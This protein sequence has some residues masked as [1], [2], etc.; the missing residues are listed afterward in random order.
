MIKLFCIFLIQGGSIRHVNSGRCLS[1]PE[2]RDVTL[3]VLK[4]CDESIS[5]QWV[6]KSRF[7]CE[8]LI[9]LCSL[10]EIKTIFLMQGKQQQMTNH[11]KIYSS[12]NFFIPMY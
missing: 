2:S 4:R 9:I 5:Q 1:K 11:F 10:I 8:E 3:P 12:S 6:M 7:K